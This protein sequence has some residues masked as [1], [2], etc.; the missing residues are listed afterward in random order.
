MPTGGPDGNERLTA[1]IGLLLVGLLVVEA[2]TTLSLHDFLAVHLFLGL[3]LLPV[4]S[5]KLA[6]TG[7][8]FVRYYTHDAAYRLRGPP[9]SSSGRSHRCS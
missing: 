3:A 7:W 5:A 6:S 8:R 2:A 4:I 1:T 9:S